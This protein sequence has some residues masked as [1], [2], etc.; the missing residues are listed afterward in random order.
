MTRLCSRAVTHLDALARAM[1]RG[2]RIMGGLPSSRRLWVCGQQ[3]AA[4]HKPHSPDLDE[5]G[6]SI[7]GEQKWV[8]SRER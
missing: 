5:K 6:W 3:E 1:D 8:I 4:A 2:T 7:S